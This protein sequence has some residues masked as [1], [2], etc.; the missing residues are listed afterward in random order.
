MKV[1]EL[2]MRKNC[3][4]AVNGVLRRSPKPDL[5]YH[6]ESSKLNYISVQCLVA[7]PDAK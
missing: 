1:L 4:C 5:I 7:D 2:A 6:L 3:F